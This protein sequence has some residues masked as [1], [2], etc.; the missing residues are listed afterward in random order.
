MLSKIAATLPA[1]KHIGSLAESFEHVRPGFLAGM[2]ALVHLH[3]GRLLAYAR[4]RGLDAEDALDAVQDSFITFFELPEARRIADRPEES[5][6]LLTVLLRHHVAN[7]RRKRVRRHRVHGVLAAEA[8]REVGEPT[9]ALITRAEEIARA[10]GCIFRMAAVQRH[11]I[12]LGLLEGLSGQEIARVL[13]ITEGYSRVLLHRAREHLRRC[14][15]E[16]DL[17]PELSRHSM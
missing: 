5:L 3:R 12:L 13:G 1:K 15:S 11:V 9:D 6:K 14:A 8:Q 17:P 10:R 2:S 7:Q 16:D 4:R